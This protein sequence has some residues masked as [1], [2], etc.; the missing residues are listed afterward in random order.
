MNERHSWKSPKRKENNQRGWDGHAALW[1]PWRWDPSRHFDGTV[2][3]ETCENKM[4]DDINSGASW[5]K[6]LMWGG[7][8]WSPVMGARRHVIWEEEGKDPGGQ[9][10]RGWQPLLQL[11]P[12]PLAT[13]QRPYFSRRC[14]VV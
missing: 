14:R 7:I 9:R 10:K 4:K 12:G 5:W 8:R 2:V 1:L 13:P 3:N 11:L 6:A